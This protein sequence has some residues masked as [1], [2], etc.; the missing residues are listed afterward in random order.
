MV[1]GMG[2]CIRKFRIPIPDRDREHRSFFR[3]NFR[4]LP[5]SEVKSSLGLEAVTEYFFSLLV[6]FQRGV[7]M[8]VDGS[9]GKREEE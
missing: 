6:N 1:Y 7:S 9:C 4:Q 5:Q 8:K 3:T 2:M